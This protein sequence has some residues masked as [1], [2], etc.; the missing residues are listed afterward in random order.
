MNQ[1]FDDTLH[2]IGDW[3]AEHQKATAVIIALAVGLIAGAVL[4]R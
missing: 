4:F 2:A 1:K 3:C